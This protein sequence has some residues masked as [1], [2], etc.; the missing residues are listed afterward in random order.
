MKA[1]LPNAGPGM[2]R[3]VPSLRRAAGGTLLLRIFSR[4][5]A[6]VITMLLARAL[7]ANGFGIYGNAMAWL[8]VL[9]VPATFGFSNLIV[10]EVAKH[11]AA[12]EWGRMRGLLSWTNRFTLLSSMGLAFV[13]GVTATWIW[14]GPEPM[15]ARAVI[16]TLA[17][18]LPL[19]ALT[20][21]RQAA[22]RGLHD[23]IR[24]QAPELLL[25]PLLLL[26]LI[27]GA[28]A[29]RGGLTA[30]DAILLHVIAAALAFAW[31][32]RI[33]Q[34]ALPE[35]LASATPVIESRL[36]LAGALPLMA[37]TGM[38]VVTT[39]SAIVVLGIVRDANE[40]GIY[41]AAS[42]G[43]DLIVFVLGAVNTAIAPTI[44]RLHSTGQLDRL[45]L[46]V[47]RSSRK[48]VL[49]TAPIAIGLF[50][51]AGPFL[52]LFGPEFAT[53][54]PVLRILTVGRIVAASM[55]AVGLMLVMADAE[56]AAMKGIAVGALATILLSIAFIP[57]WGAV[58]AA[59]AQAVGIALWNV[60]LATIAYRK[61][62]IHSTAF[63][64]W[65]WMRR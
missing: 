63:G 58:G 45:Q 61:L 29:M 59:T 60:L 42:R 18:L 33:L 54:E 6:L 35:R 2:L 36:W 37:L 27:A 3:R 55:G 9:T 5:A 28:W 44:A 26:A 53:G 20:T 62:G 22:M 13:G 52:A 51:F 41:T 56:R 31:G 48:V 15:M 39:Q 1:A 7:G 47:T 16:L 38:Q 8:K 21:M 14:G 34:R 50:L 43:A 64:D 40:V 30:V 49:A 65:K 46:L 4:G 19:T 17:L 11:L 57:L 25:R 23:A 32:H 24:G 10:R 12:Q